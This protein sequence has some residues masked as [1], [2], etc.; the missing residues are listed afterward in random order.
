MTIPWVRISHYREYRHHRWS[1]M[2]WRG[3]YW[4]VFWTLRFRY[5]R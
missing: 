4:R 3:T 1:A 5:W 2:I